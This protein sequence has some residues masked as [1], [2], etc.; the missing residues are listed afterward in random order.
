[1]KADRESD[2]AMLQ[3]QD[4][5]IRF[6]RAEGK[7]TV[8]DQAGLAIR[9]GE[10]HGLV[11]ESGSG[12]TLLA[13]AILDLLPPGAVVEAGSIRFQGLELVG[14][15]ACDLRALRGARIGM[16]FQEPMM[17]LNPA[18]RVGHQMMEA[19]RLHL[20]LDETAIRARAVEMLERVRMPDPARCLA[21]Y[22]HEF[23]GGM[24]QRI[25]LASVLMLRPALL[26]ADE[27]TTALDVLIQKEVLEIMVEIVRELGTAV[28]LITHDL[29]LVASYASNV[30]VLERGRVVENGEVKQVLARPTHP[31]TCR[32]LEALPRRSVKCAEPG[33]S[34]APL[35]E[36]DN[37]KVYFSKRSIL[38]WR[39]AKHVRAVDG[40]SFRI[41]RNETLAVVGESGS[42]KT[43]LGRALLGLVPRIAGDVLFEDQPIDGMDSRARR[44]AQ[45]RSQIVFQDPYS[46]LDPRK[47]IGQIVGEGLRHD[48]SLDGKARRER[49]VQT[50]ADVGIDPDWCRRYPHELS[51]GQ[52]QRVGIARAIIMRPQLVVADEAVSALDLTVQAQVLKLLKD[53]QHRIK[54]SYLFISHDL[55]VVEQVADRILVMYRG[56]I[57]EMGSRDDIFDRPRHPYTCALLGAV[58][59]LVADPVEGYRLQQRQFVRGETPEGWVEDRQYG[60]DQNA[61]VRLVQVGK[62]HFVAC[63]PSGQGRS[64]DIVMAHQLEKHQ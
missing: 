31:Y 30:T 8:V 25:M 12:K 43:T 14:L 52:R 29:G 51:G 42:G 5:V 7:P 48:P 50:L 19:M 11:G 4:L 10:I 26:I 44:A 9:S 40:V 45:R 61:S 28:L 46:S 62:E 56:L 21:A 58:S 22:P 2:A 13:R 6:P 37:L 27:P 1:M 54:F 55:G 18:L 24:R 57:V 60:G 49:V 36:V 23:S 38:P 33:Q 47:R 3:V 64:A 34:R 35:V 63:S 53:L 32:L 20:D 59:E 17:S 15:P 16:V 41:H 39:K